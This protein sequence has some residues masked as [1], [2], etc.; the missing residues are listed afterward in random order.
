[1]KSKDFNVDGA[2][3]D[4]VYSS[5][6]F[7]YFIL[8]IQLQRSSHRLPNSSAIHFFSSSTVSFPMFPLPGSSIIIY[9]FLVSPSYYIHPQIP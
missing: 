2:H 6:S 1:M 3:D 4:D 9:C 7:V 8:T 5:D